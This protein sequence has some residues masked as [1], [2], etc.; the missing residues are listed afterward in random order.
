MSKLEDETKFNGLG[1]Q[2]I[3]IFSIFYLYPHYKNAKK[4]YLGYF[5]RT[6]CKTQTL[7]L[8]E[9]RIR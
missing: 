8:A 1:L 4:K 2:I 7:P 9:N 6:Q 3:E 5:N